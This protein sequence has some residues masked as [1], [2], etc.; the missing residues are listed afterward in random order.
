MLVTLMQPIPPNVS[1]NATLIVGFTSILILVLMSVSLAQYLIKDVIT[2][3]KNIVEIH[4]LK[5]EISFTLII[6]AQQRFLGVSRMLYSNDIFMINDLKNDR[7]DAASRFILNFNNLR[8]L[9]L[10][11]EET[12]ILAELSRKINTSAT[13]LKKIVALVDKGKFLPAQQNFD[14]KGLP[15]QIEVYEQLK[16]FGRLQETYVQDSLKKIDNLKQRYQY[17]IIIL[18]LFLIAM[19]AGLALYTIR[20]ISSTESQLVKERQQAFTTLEHISDS[21]ISIDSHGLVDFLNPSAENLLQIDAQLAK[22]KKLHDILFLYNDAQERISIGVLKTAIDTPPRKQQFVMRDIY[23]KNIYV[24]L[25]KSTYMDIDRRNVF[26]YVIT[27]KDISTE[28]QSALALKQQAYTDLLTGLKNRYSFEHNLKVLLNQENIRHSCTILFIDLDRF[29]VINDTCGHH[30]GDELL[31]KVAALFSHNI[32]GADVL[33]RMG[34]DEFAILLQDC[35]VNEGIRIANILIEVIATFRFVWETET[36]TIGISIGVANF[37]PNSSFRIEDILRLSDA[38]CFQAKNNGRNTYCVSNLDKIELPQQKIQ[39]SWLQKIQRSINNNDIVLLAQSITPVMLDNNIDENAKKLQQILVCYK[40]DDGSLVNS[41]L[42]SSAIERFELTEN[43]D[44]QVIRTTC[45]SIQNNK[46]FAQNNV[47]VFI[48]LSA[49]TV[50]NCHT[51]DKLLSTLQGHNIDPSSICFE[52]T[53]TTAIAHLYDVK[54]F[55]SSIKSEGFHICVSDVG[56]GI[57]ST[58]YLQNLPIDYL[59]LSEILLANICNNKFNFH[60]VESIHKLAVVLGVQTI[61]INANDSE[62]L[63]TIKKIGIHY[64]LGNQPEETNCINSDV[65]MNYIVENK[66]LHAQ[67]SA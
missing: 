4:T 12:V 13:L 51:I 23:G 56:C 63:Y 62:T 48:K 52:I 32:R 47:L 34:G 65:N 38:A 59:K 49:Q 1:S 33:A 61:V 21:V 16:K 66:Q 28:R 36:F 29:K 31:K 35:D 15:S 14:N 22:G 50:I 11:S 57:T 37:S 7:T 60:M 6:S 3:Q 55:M 30:A 27:I 40:N 41:E 24:E 26:G 64:V 67:K 25:E 54:K 8:D 53:E 44:M 45:H 43:L 42:F 39:I 17:F 9:P 19:G 20:R 5:K 2:A 58:S 10:N 46:N 18:N